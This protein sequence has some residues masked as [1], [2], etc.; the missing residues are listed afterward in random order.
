MCVSWKCIKNLFSSKNT[1]INPL[2]PLP[3]KSVTFQRDSW[4]R[5]V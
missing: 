4:R 5:L 3:E 2:K 1:F